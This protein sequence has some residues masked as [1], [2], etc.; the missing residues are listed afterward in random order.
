MNC[1]LRSFHHCNSICDSGSN[2]MRCNP[3]HSPFLVGVN[4]KILLLFPFLS[5]CIFEDVTDERNLVVACVFVGFCL[6]VYSIRC[7][8][9]HYSSEPEDGE[10]T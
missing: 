2:R 1:N 6:V 9:E 3:L 4:M 8:A 10:L 5:G 7:V